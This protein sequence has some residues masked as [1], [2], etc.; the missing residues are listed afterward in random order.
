[1]IYKPRTENNLLPNI[2]TLFFFFPK[3]THSLTE[4][5]THHYAMCGAFP[6][7]EVHKYQ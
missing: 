6:R 1:M 7:S 4:M 2:K 3:A 5:K